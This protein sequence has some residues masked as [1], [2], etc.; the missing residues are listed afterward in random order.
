MAELDS[1]SFDAITWISRSL[2]DTG[3]E[4]LTRQLRDKWAEAQSEMSLA[5]SEAVDAVPWCVREAERVRQS[6][7]TLREGV[8][9]VSKRIEGVE[10]GAEEAVASIAQA[11]AVLRRVERARDMLAKVAEVDQLAD[12][13]EAIFLGGDLLSVAN[14]I[15]NMREHLET[16]SDIPEMAE[17]R[18]MLKAADDR[19]NA[20]AEPKLNSALDA[21]NVEATRAALEVFKKSGREDAFVSLFVSSRGTQLRK[22]WRDIHATLGSNAIDAFYTEVGTAIE[23]EAK[24]LQEAVPEHRSGLLSAILINVFSELDPRPATE[25]PRGAENNF[26]AANAADL[27]MRKNALSAASLAKHVIGL[28]LNDKLASPD[29]DAVS[30]ACENILQPAIAYFEAFSVLERVVACHEI[31]KVQWQSAENSS[32]DEAAKTVDQ[33]GGYLQAAGKLI[34][35]RCMERS[36]GALFGSSLNAQ[37]AAAVAFSNKAERL[38]KSTSSVGHESWTRVQA[39]LSLLTSAAT[40]ARMWSEMKDAFASEALIPAMPFIENAA[41]PCQEVNVLLTELAACKSDS[42]AAILWALSRNSELRVRAITAI[43]TYET[44]TSDPTGDDLR[45]LLKQSKD[46]V[47]ESIFYNIRRSLQSLPRAYNWASDQHG[48]SEGADLPEFSLSPLPYATE[49]GE[50]MLKIPQQLE[51]YIPDEADI[52]LASPSGTDSSDVN[53]AQR[54][55]ANVAQGAMTLFVDQILRLSRISQS[56]A[57]QLA[58]DLEYVCSVMSALGVSISESVTGVRAVLEAENIAAAV[59]AIASTEGRRTASRLAR[60]RGVDVP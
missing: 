52:V 14:A 9:K 60:L 21:R 10:T 11:D 53:F 27:T 48:D 13:I 34:A 23:Q 33:A 22:K 58:V 1:E 6:G 40:L 36:N 38:L 46:L 18:N 28:C 51:P 56:G 43:Q 32:L 39:S 54:W 41:G 30:V 2:A 45:H 12:R 15:A 47:F 50:H 49:I 59:Q 31:D 7:S 3:P 4:D 19:L 17:K 26:S 29:P 44:S 42:D 25:L 37:K 8:D 5:L 55:I 35:E 20:M 57:S 24:W 16:L